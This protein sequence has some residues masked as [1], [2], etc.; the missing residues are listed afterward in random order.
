MGKLIYKTFSEEDAMHGKSGY[1]IYETQKAYVIKHL[2]NNNMWAP[3]YV[4]YI[5]K[6]ENLLK[7][8]AFP[9]KPEEIINDHGTTE[10]DCWLHAMKEINSRPDYYSYY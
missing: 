4:I 3:S 6:T 9:K 10:F 5:K 8:L 2:S 7:N 1:K